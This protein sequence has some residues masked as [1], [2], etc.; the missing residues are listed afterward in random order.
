MNIFSSVLFCLGLAAITV[1]LLVTTFAFMFLDRFM[2]ARVQHR[3]GPSKA[4]R[5][6]PFQ[7]WSDFRK[8]REKKANALPLPATTRLAFLTWILLPVLFLLILLGGLLPHALDPSGVAILLLLPLLALG[9]EGAFL[10]ATQDSLEKEQWRRALSLRL[11][12]IS[13]LALAFLAVALR[14]GGAS[15]HQISHAQRF[16]PYLLGLS[17]PGLF[18][19]ALSAFGAVFVFARTGAE[20]TMSSQ[21][22]GGALH[23]PIFFTKKMW[24]VS[25]LSFWVF[26]FFGGSSGIVNIALFPLKLALALFFLLLIQLSVPAVKSVDLGEIAIRWVLR[27][28]LI[29]L[30]IEAVWLGVMA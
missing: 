28:S 27:L 15:L 5:I 14:V 17:G 21:S 6:N 18:C 11:L 2:R 29:S 25:L 13:I 4:G 19:S 22:L 24:V 16:F 12:G 30:V 9:L 3:D 26:V 8:I 7:V 1:F 10:H 23:F 20:E